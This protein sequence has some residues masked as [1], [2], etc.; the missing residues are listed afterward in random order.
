MNALIVG[1]GNIGYHL[2]KELSQQ[3]QENIFVIDSDPERIAAVRD[4]MD[5]L[6][7]HGDATNPDILRK[8]GINKIDT[9]I[10]VT[11]SDEV[12]LA[13]SMMVRK[14]GVPFIIAR[15]RRDEW[16][17]DSLF[18]VEDLGVQ[19]VIHPELE[20]AQ[21]L[22]DILRIPGATRVARFSDE[23]LDLV[24]MRLDRNVPIAGKPLKEVR[25]EIGL[26]LFL[27]SGILR[28]DDFFIPDGDTVLQ[29]DDECYLLMPRDLVPLLANVFHPSPVPLKRALVFGLGYKGLK[30]V[31]TLR[32]LEV[33]VVAIESDRALAEKRSE[34]LT[35]VDI[36]CKDVTDPVSMRELGLGPSDCFIAATDEDHDNSFT[37]LLAK[38]MGCD[39]VAAVVDSTESISLLKS[40]GIDIV[41]NPYLMAAGRI[42][43]IIM[44]GK[45]ESVIRLGAEDA[46]FIEMVVTSKHRMTGTPLRK[47]RIPKGILIACIVRGEDYIIPYGDTVIEEDDRLFL[48]TTRSGRSRFKDLL[49][50]SPWKWSL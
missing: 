24:T 36:F 2:T 1:V 10:V 11:D 26:D 47:L 3:E 12:N 13:V 19:A 43:T 4:Q 6:A 29:G 42:L 44:K 22:A 27:I 30:I 41:L 33:D 14:M 37:A 48:A 20:L 50:K 8:V 23:T 15:I 21:G 16:F 35:T 28:G 17:S 18:T 49:E 34:L 7:I 9:A 39:R 32:T 46:E 31:Q 40:L 25:S 38:R 45:V 5:V